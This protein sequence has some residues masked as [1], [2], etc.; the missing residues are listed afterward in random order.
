MVLLMIT[1]TVE[2]V[3]ETYWAGAVSVACMKYLTAF[4]M[5]PFAIV[6]TPPAASR[7]AT[8]PA[9]AAGT[10]KFILPLRRTIR[11][12]NVHDGSYAYRVSP[13]QRRHGQ[14]TCI[15]ISINDV[16]IDMLAERG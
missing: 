6:T 2:A 8:W 9:L 10:D 5:L 15:D 11:E 13:N 16:Y 3:N 1:T 14:L 7:L 4:P 12:S